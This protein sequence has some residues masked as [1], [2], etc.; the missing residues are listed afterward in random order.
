MDGKHDY[1]FPTPHLFNKKGL[2]NEEKSNKQTWTK[3]Q[4]VVEGFFLQFFVFVFVGF[5]HFWV[6]P[7]EKN[8]ESWKPFLASKHMAHTAQSSH[9]WFK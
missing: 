1:L 8:A 5:H 4:I 3:E 7:F 9:D 2:K 6:P